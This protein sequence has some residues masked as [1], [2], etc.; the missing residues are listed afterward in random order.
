MT[1]MPPKGLSF[2]RRKRSFLSISINLSARIIEISSI[3]RMVNALLFKGFAVFALIAVQSDSMLTP[4]ARSNV[5]CAVAPLT[6]K[7]AT[8][9]G[10]TVMQ[11]SPYIDWI[12][13]MRYVFPQPAGPETKTFSPL[14]IAMR[15]ASVPTSYCPFSITPPRR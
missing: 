9:V 15:A 1:C 14:M 11:E 7:A 3:I 5:R 8:P 13:L 2:F 4:A 10:A 12:M 6:F